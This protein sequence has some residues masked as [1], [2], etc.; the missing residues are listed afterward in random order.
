MIQSNTIYYYFFNRTS[1]SGPNYF[2]GGYS[3]F[4]EVWRKQ[5]EILQPEFPINCPSLSKQWPASM[6]DCKRLFSLSRLGKLNCSV[7][8][9]FF[10]Y[11]FCFLSFFFVN[12]PAI[13]V[14]TVNIKT[15]EVFVKWNTTQWVENDFICPQCVLHTET[16]NKKN[17]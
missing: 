5:T 9:L 14:C 7:K 2:V 15:V 3:W 12:S 11:S 17:K 16:H 8:F 4:S 6:E 10:L 13:E 1:N